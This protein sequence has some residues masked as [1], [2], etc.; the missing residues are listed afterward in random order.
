[1]LNCAA[2]CKIIADLKGRSAPS[3]V[4]SADP[5][6]DTGRTALLETVSER[7]TKVDPNL[8]GASLTTAEE[9]LVGLTHAEAGFELVLN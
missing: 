1:M 2:D 7:Y 9:E 6:H 8:A 3:G 5:L 4:F